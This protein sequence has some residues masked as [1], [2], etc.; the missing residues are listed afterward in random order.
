M[1]RLLQHFT[2]NSVVDFTSWTLSSCRK[3]CNQV[4]VTCI[5]YCVY[6]DRD[7]VRTAHH[8]CR[9]CCYWVCGNIVLIFIYI[10]KLR[11]LNFNNFQGIYNWIQNV[12]QHYFPEVNDVEVWPIR[13][14]RELYKL[15][16]EHDITAVIKIASVFLNFKAIYPLYVWLIVN[17]ARIIWAGY[18]NRM[19]DSEITDSYELWIRSK[20]DGRKVQSKMKWRE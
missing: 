15:F 3:S 6:L 16:K 14:N 1:P 2:H 8:V 10:Y 7:T 5:W 12:I 18:V 13:Y 9:K 19:S 20:N 11:I 4:G 17:T